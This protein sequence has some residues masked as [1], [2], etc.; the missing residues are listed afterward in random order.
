MGVRANK[1]LGVIGKA[2]NKLKGGAGGAVDSSLAEALAKGGGITSSGK[3]LSSSE[4]ASMIKE[5]DKSHG[6]TPMN[7]FKNKVKDKANDI[8]KSKAVTSTVSNADRIFRPDAKTVDYA[9]E[10]ESFARA[11]ITSPNLTMGAR[12]EIGLESV[13]NA[14]RAIKSYATQGTRTDM[15]IRAAGIGTAAVGVN[16]LV[17]AAGDNDIVGNRLY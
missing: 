16:A 4:R 5:L 14:G 6:K 12:G 2:I 9:L 11:A 10:S 8:A 7:A 1:G 15:A 13:K 17:N 3:A